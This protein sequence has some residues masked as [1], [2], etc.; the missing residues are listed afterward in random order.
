MIWREIH[1]DWMQG[2]WNKRRVFLQELG[3]ESTPRT[4]ASAAVVRAVKAAAA[5][6][7]RALDPGDARPERPASSTAP[8][9]AAPLGASKRK[10][11]Q[12]CPRKKDFKTRVPRA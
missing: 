9:A 10:R 12:M 11:C 8:A 1:P 3:R 6:A 4:E 2:K 5:A 7:P